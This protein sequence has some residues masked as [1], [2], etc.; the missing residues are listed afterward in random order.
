VSDVP[1]IPEKSGVVE[2]FGVN[3]EDVV[4]YHS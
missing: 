1:V 3:V 4:Q 2:E